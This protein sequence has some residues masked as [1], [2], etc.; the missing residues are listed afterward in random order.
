MW[1]MYMYKDICISTY[2]SIRT[3]LLLLFICTVVFTFCLLYLYVYVYIDVK[4]LYE[5]L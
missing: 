1:D 4:Y 3:Y 5:L 2:L